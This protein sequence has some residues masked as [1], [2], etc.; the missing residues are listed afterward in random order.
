MKT[1]HASQKLV[2]PSLM[3]V[4]GALAGGA[5]PGCGGAEPGDE[6][7]APSLATFPGDVPAGAVQIDEFIAHVRPKEGKVVI[8]RVVRGKSGPALGP[9]SVD[10]LPIVSDSVAGSGP[11]STV[12]LVTETNA[13]THNQ[14]DY[15]ANCPGYTGAG[16]FCANVTL[17]H[18]Y[19]Q[20]L[21]NTFV[22]VTAITDAT[23]GADVSSNH[24]AT[25]SDMAPS[26]PGNAIDG[27]KGLWK[28]TATGAQLGSL[29]MAPDNAGLRTWVFNNPDNANTNILLRVFA[30]LKYSDYG[31]FNSSA[32][33]VD[34]CTLAGA[35][36]STSAGNV[37]ATLP[38]TFTF[39]NQQ[40]STKVNYNRDGVLTFGTTTP[41]SSSNAPFKNVGLPE[42]PTKFSV[43][44]GVFVMWDSL[45]YNPTGSLCSGT[46]GTAPSRRF[47]IT[48]KNMKVFGGATN[49][50]NLTFSAMLNEGNDRIDMVYSSMV[51][52]NG[53]NQT[54]ANGGS[55]VVGVQ[56]SGTGSSNISTPFP[57]TISK[58]STATNVKY[59]YTPIP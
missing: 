22:Q 28:Y 56:G 9:E 12:E 17:R 32:T 52:S 3:F 44:P 31:R 25:N 26:W 40:A 15:N 48:W 37:S 7:S 53:P 49:A 34:A 2:G 59:T 54:R 5:L 57:A 8:E 21:N 41:P 51:G 20:N 4:A 42:N 30:T 18:F 16:I 13:T 43:S 46:S 19:A 45:D 14:V 33:F 36:V 23:T 11:A 29:G 50:E 35:S 24:A 38:F 6:G 55:A 58:S 10:A 47:V 39:Y 27:S 1:R